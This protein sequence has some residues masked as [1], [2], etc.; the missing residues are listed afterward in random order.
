MSGARGAA[1][2][3]ATLDFLPFLEPPNRLSDKR[4]VYFVDFN[5]D[6]DMVPDVDEFRALIQG[7]F[8]RI[9]SLAG[10]TLSDGALVNLDPEAKKKKRSRKRAA[11]V[12]PITEISREASSPPVK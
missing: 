5:A 1:L 12:A 6:A 10:V 2:C 8:A 4:F 3:P 11:S 9:A 7:A